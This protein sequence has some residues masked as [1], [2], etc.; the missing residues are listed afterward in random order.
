MKFIRSRYPDREK[1]SSPC[2]KLTGR[3]IWADADW[4]PR[5]PFGISLCIRL[6]PREPEPCHKSE[7]KTDCRCEYAPRRFTPAFTLDVNAP[8]GEPNRLYI[9]GPR[10]NY[11]IG[12]LSWHTEVVTHVTTEVHRGKE[13]RISHMKTVRCWP[14][15]VRGQAWDRKHCE[16]SRGKWRVIVISPND[17][18]ERWARAHPEEAAAAE[19][20]RAE[21]AARAAAG[22]AADEQ[23]T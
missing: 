8:L 5:F 12:L 23:G 13:R 21:H 17:H 4:N 16:W 15:L 1:Y 10:R 20:H 11:M 7:C 19:R 3:W 6:G 18:R 2:W 22:K 14:R 9:P